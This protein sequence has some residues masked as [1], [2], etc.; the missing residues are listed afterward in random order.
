MT[1]CSDFSIVGTPVVINISE[2]TPGLGSAEE[3]VFEVKAPVTLPVRS[4]TPAQAAA[5]VPL[6]PYPR[7]PF[8][9]AADTRVTLRYVLT[10]LDNEPRTVELLLEP[11]NEFVRYDPGPPVVSEEEVLIN[12]SGINR[13]VILAPM[14]RSVGIITPDDFV[15]LAKDLGTVQALARTP[16]PTVEGDPFA[17]P[18]LFNRAFNVQNRDGATDPL[19]KQYVPS[20][21]AAITGF[22][23]GLRARAKMRV[24]L[25]VTY[26]IVDV[27]GERV[28]RPG[29]GQASFARPG[30]VITPPAPLP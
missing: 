9:N 16:R 22:D 30:E 11:W 23:I 26:E 18:T 13:F 4:P 17:G 2:T 20:V 12:L 8:V 10:N 6:A 25:D 21:A 3:P 15:E 28:V 1:S 29:E 14:E 5:L 19:L 7:T 27:N 24:S